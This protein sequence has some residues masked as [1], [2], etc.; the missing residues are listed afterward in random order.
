MIQNDRDFINA[1]RNFDKG[2]TALDGLPEHARNVFL[3]SGQG[4]EVRALLLKLQ[5]EVADSLQ[6]FPQTVDD[7]T[8]CNSWLAER[9]K[10]RL[11]ERGDNVESRFK[12][13]IWKGI[14]LNSDAT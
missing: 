3:A 13:R 6:E 12:D 5:A 4:K 1:K 14:G 2:R 10:E 9:L 11:K 8:H 7:E